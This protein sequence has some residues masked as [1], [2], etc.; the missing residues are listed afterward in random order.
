MASAL[1]YQYRST[2]WLSSIGFI[3]FAERSFTS[4]VRKENE[5]LREERKISGTAAPS[6]IKVVDSA[7]LVAVGGILQQHVMGTAAPHVPE[8]HGDPA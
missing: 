1:R 4:L 7:S 2:I 6:R 8:T 5:K 3:S